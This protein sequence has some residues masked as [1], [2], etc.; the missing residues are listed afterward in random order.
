[1]NCEEEQLQRKL[2]ETSS[3]SDALRALC[4][5]RVQPVHYLLLKEHGFSEAEIKAAYNEVKL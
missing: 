4:D 1:M 5:A 3:A 2:D